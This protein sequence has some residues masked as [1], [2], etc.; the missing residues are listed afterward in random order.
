M[1]DEAS[2]HFSVAFS[3]ACAA[4]QC[5]LRASSFRFFELRPATLSKDVVPFSLYRLHFDLDPS[6]DTF[7]G[8]A[9]IALRIASAAPSF[10]IHAHEL[11]ADTAPF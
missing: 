3:A 4:V 8:T 10:E 9:S 6:K 5:G 11:S 7:S 1:I 2:I